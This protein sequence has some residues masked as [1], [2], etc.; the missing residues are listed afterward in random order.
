MYFV[1]ID[2]SKYKHDCFITTETGDV[3]SNSFTINNNQDGFQQLLTIL[4]SL[5]NQDEIRI[6]FESTGH[7]ALNLKL[8]LEKAH[9]SFMEFN[10]VLLAKF[11]KSQT[12]RCT[13]TDAIDCASIARWLMTVEYKP[14]PIGFYH[15]YSLK[16]LT[17][18]RDTLVKQR[19]FYIVKMT[20]VLDHTFPEFKPFFK[21][22]F[23][24]TA[25][26]LLENYG[27]AEKIS[28]M[29]ASSYENLRKISR[30]KFS[31]QKFL[32][33]KELAANT[34][35]ENNEIF[36]AQ[37]NSLMALYNQSVIEVNAL[38][39]Q[40][41]WLIENINPH[42]LTIPGIGALS[43]AVIYA[44]YGDISKFNSS[45]QMLSF[46][47]LEPGYYQSGTS[48]HGG[49]MVKRGSSHLRFTLMNLCIPLIQY[50][51]V[52]AEYYAKKRSEGK[53]H[54]VTCSHVIKK[55]IR[56]IFTL[57]KNNIDFD[58]SKLR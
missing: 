50:N 27:C 47:G 8:F 33:L 23:S 53:S 7:Y 43:A 49:H 36:S 25:L 29:N 58:A 10:P 15:T 22:R 55:L 6:G 42:F 32:K 37:L 30:G 34:V 45:S 35:G 3:V 54:R 31:M 44:E 1:G 38:E 19:S 11:N 20:N 9:Y 16:S 13:K 18:L 48:V 28:R 24:K 40:I 41:I 14:Y 26:Y 5:D 21:N 4:N 51:M 17:R 39:Q 56:I 52:F 12:L 57:E 2:I 46:A